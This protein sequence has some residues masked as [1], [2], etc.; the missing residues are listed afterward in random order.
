MYDERIKSKLKREISFLHD[1]QKTNNIKYPYDRAEKFN[2]NM[3]KLNLDINENFIDQ[4]RATV[5]HI[6]KRFKF[7]I[8]N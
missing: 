2:S 3:R 7:H 8:F 6:G 5:T 4:F 1:I